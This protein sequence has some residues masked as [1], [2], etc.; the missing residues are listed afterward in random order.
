[1]PNAITTAQL[2][3]YKQAIENGGASAA[4][5]VYAELYAQ[6]YNYAGWAEGVAKGNS[7]T[8]LSALDFLKDSYFAATCNKLSDAQIDKIRSDMAARTLDEYIEISKQS[9]GELTRDLNYAETK[10][11]HKTDRRF[12]RMRPS[13]APRKR[14]QAG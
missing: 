4:A 10:E 3:Q 2:Q 9:G 11:I 8:G 7:I 14:H 1:M 5:Q 13:I 6:G 12:N